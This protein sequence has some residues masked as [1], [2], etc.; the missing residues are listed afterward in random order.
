[1]ESEAKVD[2]ED[3]LK[4]LG[5]A[6]NRH[7]MDTVVAMLDP[8]FVEYT[9]AVPEPVRGRDAYRKIQEP[10]FSAFPDVEFRVLNTIAKGDTVAREI[11]AT[12][13]FKGP[14]ELAGRTL[15]PTGRRVEIRYAELCQV[16]SKGLITEERVY[17]DMVETSRQLGLKA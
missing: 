8:N 6:W 12:G 16:N 13:T 7:D 17:M 14:F 11:L 3:V 1:M 5:A 15:P 10:M 4:R 2:P 9:P